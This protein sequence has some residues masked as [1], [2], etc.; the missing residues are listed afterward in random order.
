MSC[1]SCGLDLILNPWPVSLI[2]D[3]YVKQPQECRD[4]SVLGIYFSPCQFGHCSITGDEYK[5]ISNPKM[6]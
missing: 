2:I 5:F 3:F 4:S 6:C 1:V